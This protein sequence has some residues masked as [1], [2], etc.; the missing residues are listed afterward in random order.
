MLHN[1]TTQDLGAQ[2]WGAALTSVGRAIAGRSSMERETTVATLEPDSRRSQ[3]ENGN[4]D[5]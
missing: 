5:P 2:L 3:Q 4:Q 1:E